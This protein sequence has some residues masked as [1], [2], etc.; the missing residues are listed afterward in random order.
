MNFVGNVEGRD[1]MSAEIDVCVTDGFTGNV[2][3]KTLE[4]S[5]KF[6]IGALFEAFGQPE[7]KEHADALMP[8]LIPLYE[9]LNPDTY[10]GAVLLGVDGVCIIAHGSSGATAITNGI[11]VAREL[12]EYDLVGEI[13]DVIAAAMPAD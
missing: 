5:M 12:V 1:V 9:S 2:V 13:R 7:Y 3:L 4:G 10:G 11:A 6:L 8:A